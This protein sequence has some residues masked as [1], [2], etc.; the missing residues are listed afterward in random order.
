MRNHSQTEE[1]F[2][3]TSVTTPTYSF[4][5]FF[6]KIDLLLLS[7]TFSSS[8]IKLYYLTKTW[9]APSVPIPSM[10]LLANQLFAPFNHALKP[11]ADPATKRSS[12]AITS[13]FRSA[14]SATLTSLILSFNTSDS[15]SSSF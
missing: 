6:R 12:V 15:Q 7:N 14:S 11:H 4:S 10:S 8:V 9:P 1:P 5:F 13:L 2:T 3:H